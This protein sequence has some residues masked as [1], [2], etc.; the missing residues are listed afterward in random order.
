METLRERKKQRTRDALVRSALELFTT[1]GYER[2]TVDEIA[3]AVEVSQRTFFRYFAGKEE[4]A[5]AVQ[6]MTEAHFVAA[7]RARPAHE[8]P[9]EALRQAVLDGW[10][11]IRETVESA[12]PVELY[13]RMYRTIESTPALL[14]AH[15]RRSAAT[16]ETIARLLAEREGVDVDTDPRPRLA[17]AVFGGVIRVTERQWSTGDDFSLLAMRQLTASHLDQVGSAL[18][19]NWRVT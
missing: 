11:A 4:V 19:G 13:L 10:D 18:I 15:L 9:M 1:Q 6:E 5:F 12:V 17:V 2:T 7:V 8:A 16:E 3:G 14:A